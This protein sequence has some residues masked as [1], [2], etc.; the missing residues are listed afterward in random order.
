MQKLSI[1]ILSYNTRDITLSCVE[2]LIASLQE[3]SFNS[4]IIVVDNASSDDS[5]SM[6]KNVKRD[7]S[8]DRIEIINIFNKE[9]VGYPKGNNQGIKIAR[10]E[11]VLFL[12]SDVIIKDVNWEELLSYMDHN[13]KIG[14]LTVRVMLPTGGIDRA[15]HRGFPTVWN[16]FSYY[17]GLEKATR[18]IP[19]VNRWFG[20]YHLTHKK[21]TE[22]HEIDALSGAFFLTRKKLV[23]A[24]NG[25]DET[26]FMYGEDLDLAYRMKELDYKIVYYPLSTVLH[27]KYQSGLKKGLKKTESKTKKHFYDAMKIFYKKHYEASNPSFLNKI[28]YSF[29]DLK[30]KIS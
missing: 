18:H 29:I 3:T 16:A 13:E 21:L 14:A 1:I 19:F 2:S 24:M 11:Y 6:L 10:G 12:N 5:V 28:V 25:F 4:E 30:E 26:F 20:G 23:Q 9:N 17:S 7:F 15:S 8:S 22:I 27:L